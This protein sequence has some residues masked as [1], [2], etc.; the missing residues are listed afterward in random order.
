MA[1][2]ARRPTTVMT[3]LGFSHALD[4]TYQ[5]LLAQSGRELVSVA[6]AL[7]KTPEE[8]LTEIAPLLER[9]V[10]VVDAE[11]R[12]HVAEPTEAVARI[13]G[14]T[15]QAAKN[16][17]TQLENVAAAVPFLTGAS[18]RL[19]PDEVRDVQ[20]IDGE[21]SSGGDVV[22]LLEMLIRQ[23]PGDLLW[24][25]PDLFLQPREDAMASAV[26]AA[27]DAGRQSRAIYPVR[28]LT[29]ARATLVERARVG[30]QIR[31]LPT[32]PTRMLVIGST[33]A[34]LPEPLGFVDEPR[35]LI[36][37]RG[38]VEALAL[39]FESLWDRADP[40]HDLERM[41]PRPDLR[42]FLLEQLADGAQD[43]LIARRLGVSLRT[44]RRRVADTM[45][46]LGAESRFQ[47]GVEAVRRGWL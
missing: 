17:Q 12:V 31:V 29:E 47:A 43:E 4:R 42:R 20:Q 11:S 7:L 41:E 30:E 35:T 26:R 16:A 22:P 19:G 6:R 1:P 32:L 15:A 39:W 24:L 10:V 34:I 2:A 28:A 44:V 5:R 45:A 13:L 9:D 27:V 8:L 33:H 14:A 3:A 38:L 46:E 40:V 23:S 21:I 37:Q 25:R 18:T 36:R